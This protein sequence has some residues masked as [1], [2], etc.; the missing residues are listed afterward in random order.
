MCGGV[1]ECEGVCG[2]VREC[3]GVCGSVWGVRECGE[4]GGEC[5]EMCT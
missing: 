4:G 2:G 3:V 1:R 5:T